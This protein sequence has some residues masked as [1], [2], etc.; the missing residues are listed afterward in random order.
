MSVTVC[1]KL[2]V[3]EYLLM[4]RILEKRHIT[5]YAWIRD[6]LVKGLVAE[7]GDEA[8]DSTKGKEGKQKSLIAIIKDQKIR[9]LKRK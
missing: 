5:R 2:S 1:S 4:T 9:E 6:Q 3:E 7:F 8:K